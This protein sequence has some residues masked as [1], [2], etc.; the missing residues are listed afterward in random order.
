MSIHFIT[1]NGAEVAYDTSRHYAG[2]VFL[3][4]PEPV[5]EFIGHRVPDT[6][7]QYIDR[8]W[9]SVRHINAAQ[10]I[11][12]VYPWLCDEPHPEP[13]PLL[14][15]NY[16]NATIVERGILLIEVADLI[17]RPINDRRAIYAELVA[18]SANILARMVAS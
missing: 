3:A 7:D 17:L 2:T 4:S 11:A 12:T 5:D 16:T 8:L 18:R 6:D 13:T 15:P 10:S 1:T 14:F 9:V